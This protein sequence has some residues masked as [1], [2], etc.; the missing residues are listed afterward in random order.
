MNTILITRPE[1]AATHDAVLWCQAGFDV[2]MAP[3]LTVNFIPVRLPDLKNYQAIITTSAQAILA[4]AQLT[5]DRDFPLWCVGQS[6]AKV[7]AD[8]GFQKVFMPIDS[9]ENALGL[10]DSIV[11]Y[12]TGPLLYLSGKHVQFNMVDAL[13]EKGVQVDQVVLYETQPNKT[14]WHQMD[15][16][17]STP[18]KKG[19]TFYSRRTAQVFKEYATA[20]PGFKVDK[21]CYALA[22]SPEIANLIQP[23]FYESPIIAS[24][25]TRLIANL[26][27]D[28]L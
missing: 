17:F 15:H 13:T 26:K 6:S 25:T 1:P 24:T 18:D 12:L 28:V 7:A 22:L 20:Q 4:L 27:E 14:V 21:G 11:Q 2:V 19:V 9:Q 8:C 16:F 23:F 10:A 5:T 3:L